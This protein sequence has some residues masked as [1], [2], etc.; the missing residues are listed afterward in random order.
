MAKRE[1]NWVAV[2]NRLQ[3][4]ESEKE[5]LEAR[6]RGLV[7]L[8][9]PNPVKKEKGKL[10]GKEKKKLDAVRERKEGRI[11]KK[12]KTERESRPPKNGKSKKG[13]M[14]NKMHGKVKK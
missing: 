6:K 5:K 11:W 7:E 12:G 13:G 4:F 10:S 8:N 9:G 3:P 14:K 1:I 2:Q